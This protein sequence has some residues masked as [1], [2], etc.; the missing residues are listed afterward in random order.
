MEYSLNKNEV[1]STA[2]QI[3]GNG[4]DQSHSPLTKDE[5]QC[6]IKKH[7]SNYWKIL[8]FHYP[9]TY[10]NISRCSGG[11][12]SEKTYRWIHGISCT[13]VCSCGKSVNYIGISDGYYSSCRVCNSKKNILKG[14]ESARTE[15]SKSKRKSTVLKKYGV[16]TSV[17]LPNAVLNRKSSLFDK[18]GTL[19]PLQVE[20][21]REKIKNTKRSN[22]V[23]SCFS[24]DRCSGFIPTFSPDEFSGV[25]KFYPFKCNAC[26][27]TIFCHM[28][29][30][31]SPRCPKCSPNSLL[32]N[33]LD[34]LVRSVY[35][36]EIYRNSR[37]VLPSG[38]ELD[39][40]IPELHIAIELNGIYWHSNKFKSQY[41][42]MNKFLECEKMNIR[43]HQI[44]E[45][46]MWIEDDALKKSLCRWL[47][48]PKIEVPTDGV[49]ILESLAH[50]HISF[51]N[52]CEYRIANTIE[53]KP[54]NK[55]VCGNKE[56]IV[57]D[58][59]HRIWEPL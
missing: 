54:C 19:Y 58:S 3:R 45:N 57:F 42:H 28:M 56:F 34:E 8:K 5:V 26:E 16:N 33:R 6:I 15:Y 55:I 32:E 48:V 18:F 7:T 38:L 22:F 59:G 23:N 39:F 31:T 29:W 2:E 1:Q 46:E 20:S 30:G 51:V 10:T 4:K 49:L 11:S 27:T 50:P 12:F 25:G 41:Y 40:Y 17:E 35:T 43:L 52:P 47:D 9:S 21:V 36:G 37:N 24:G 13:P 14:I 53:P 44:F